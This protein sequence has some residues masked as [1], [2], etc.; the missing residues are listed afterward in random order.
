VD[1]LFQRGKHTGLIVDRVAL[2]CATETQTTFGWG[3]RQ[4]PI[5]LHLYHALHSQASR[6]RH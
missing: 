3:A 4:Q 5:S 2:Y 1:L 6:S